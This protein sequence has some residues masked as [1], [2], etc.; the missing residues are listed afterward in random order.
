MILLVILGFISVAGVMIIR[1]KAEYELEWIGTYG[2]H[3]MVDDE[4]DNNFYREITINAEI[5]DVGDGSSIKLKVSETPRIPKFV[6]QSGIQIGT[7]TYG[8][9]YIDKKDMKKNFVIGFKAAEN[10][11]EF[12]LFAEFEYVDDTHINIRYA[13]KQTDLYKEEFKELVRV[14]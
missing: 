9:S 1:T 14:Q 6:E 3:F 11:N 8:P 10:D 13:V 12:N 5:I 4:E 2:K 7:S